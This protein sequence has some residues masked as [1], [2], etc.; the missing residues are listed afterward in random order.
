MN[1]K[2]III[3]LIIILFSVTL[4]SL[5]FDKYHEY[6][7]MK[8]KIEKK[9]PLNI[10]MT[11]HTKKMPRR[12]GR[13]IEEMKKKNPEFNFYMYDDDDCRNMIKNMTHLKDPYFMEILWAYDNLIP[14]AFKADLW[15]YCVLYLYGGIYLDIKMKCLGDFKLID[16]ID[17]EYYVMD[18][19][20]YNDDFRIY[21]AV[22]VNKKSSPILLRCIEKIIENCKKKYYGMNNLSP[23]GPGLFGNLY[24]K[25]KK[26]YNLPEIILFFDGHVIKKNDKPIIG[27]YNGYRLD[28][29]VN[30]KKM[31]YSIL[32][33][34]NK[35]YKN[36][37]IYFPEEISIP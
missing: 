23:T 20:K 32:W 36:D 8:H 30:Q 37:T 12:M 34:M 4:S 16:L 28:Q 1:I 27:K 33:K 10:F 26:E 17:N 22:M 9:I 15:R 13:N 35:I 5:S 31:H 14:G 19:Y 29:F 18:H 11:W 2:I 3:L 24:L 6:F 25:Y 21:Q 7:S